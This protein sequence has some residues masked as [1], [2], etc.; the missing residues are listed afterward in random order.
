M[1]P[2]HEMTDGER[3]A[4]AYHDRGLRGEELRDPY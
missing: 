1:K 2:S 3:A 4:R